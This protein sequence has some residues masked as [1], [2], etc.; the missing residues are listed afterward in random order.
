MK[1]TAANKDIEA[2]ACLPSFNHLVVAPV[3]L[4]RVWPEQRSRPCLRWLREQQRVC[5]M[6]TTR[7]GRRALFCPAHV[8]AFAGNKLT[9]MSQRT[10]R[11]SCESAQLP[12]PDVLID[13]VGLLEFLMRDF[14]LKRSLRWVRQQ[15][16][17]RSLPFIKWGG[18]VFFAPAQIRAA[19]RA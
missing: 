19:L 1:T 14:G 16:E 10:A 6:P 3:L 12:T 13:A 17:N 7:V 8:L 5:A 18:K 9:V 11:S 15:Q 2:Q 4:E